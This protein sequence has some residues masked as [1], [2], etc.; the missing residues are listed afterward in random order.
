M[1]PAF[2]EAAWALKPGEIS[3]VVES[4]FG[5]HV[6]KVTDKRGEGYVPMA[7]VKN[8]ID[9]KLKNDRVQAELEKLRA[10]LRSGAKVNITL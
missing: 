2:D 4:Q 7:D 3:G 6:I 9:Q 10:S 1:V 8:Q 5:Y